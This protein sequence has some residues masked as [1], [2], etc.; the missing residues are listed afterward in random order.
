[1]PKKKVPMKRRNAFVPKA[2]E[3]RITLPNGRELGKK[4]KK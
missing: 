2:S 4:P 1:M 3:L